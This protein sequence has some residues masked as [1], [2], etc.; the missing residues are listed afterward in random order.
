MFYQPS[1]GSV[2]TINVNTLAETFVTS[3]P[4]NNA[5][6]IQVQYLNWAE[7]KW[8]PDGRWIAFNDAAGTIFKI[9]VDAEGSPAGSPVPLTANPRLETGACWSADSRT[10]FFHSELSFTADPLLEQFDLWAVSASGGHPVRLTD[11]TGHGVTTGCWRNGNRI[12]Y[13][14]INNGSSER[15]CRP[16]R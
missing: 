4:A 1:D 2:R 13:A 11:V 15:G 14:G 5:G 8:S 9:R 12:A 3:I 16:K 7:P 6:G 10:L